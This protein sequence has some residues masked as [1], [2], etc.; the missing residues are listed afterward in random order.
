MKAVFP[1]EHVAHPGTVKRNVFQRPR[2]ARKDADEEEAE[3]DSMKKMEKQVPVLPGTAW[4]RCHALPA[5]GTMHMFMSCG[6]SFA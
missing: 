6:S 3:E 2:V 1:R 4:N 5:K